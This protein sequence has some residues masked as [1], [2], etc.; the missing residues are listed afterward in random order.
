M[1]WKRDH[2]SYLDFIKRRIES[3]EEDSN[4]ETNVKNVLEKVLEDVKYM[5]PQEI[6]QTITLLRGKKWP[7]KKIN[8]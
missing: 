3:I 6:Q 7:L 8:R 1:I 5:V 4:F 2:E